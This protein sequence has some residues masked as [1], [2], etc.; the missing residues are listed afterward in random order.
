VL[1]HP[2]PITFE[3][4]AD[5]TIRFLKQVVG[6]PARL[7]VYSN[8]ADL[9]KITSRT[10]VKQG[11]DDEVAIEHALTLYRTV[12]NSKFAIIP[13]TSHGLLAPKP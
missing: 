7:P 13:G 12:P 9:S 10:L 11:D 4:M 5:D 1:V 6:G 3:L 2:G 8:G